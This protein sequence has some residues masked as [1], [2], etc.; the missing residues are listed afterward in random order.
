MNTKFK[1]NLEKLESKNF[2]SMVE[3]DYQ[4]KILDKSY[5]TQLLLSK[6]IINNNKNNNSNEEGKCEKRDKGGGEGGRDT[7]VFNAYQMYP[8]D[9][10]SRLRSLHYGRK[11]DG[12]NPKYGYPGP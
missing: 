4:L 5:I 2:I 10:F 1:G 7:I 8:K 6:I 9:S 11:V 3:K 12:P